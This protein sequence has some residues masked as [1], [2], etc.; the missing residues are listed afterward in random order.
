MSATFELQKAI[1]TTLTGAGLR[2]YDFAPQSSD[3]AATATYPYVEVG[4]I[5]ASEWDTNSELGFDAVCRIHTRSRSGSTLECRNI[6]DQIY[7]ALHR[8]TLTVIGQ[9][10]ITIT[11]EM[12]DC[13]RLQDGSFHG[14]CEYRALLET[15]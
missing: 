8:A 5:V 9:N 7:D 14:V 6:Q 15:A 3:G 4:H 10:T 2:V 1:Y 12:S 11:R 13:T